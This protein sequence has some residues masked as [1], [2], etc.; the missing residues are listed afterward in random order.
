M[1]GD[2]NVSWKNLAKGQGTETC[3]YDIAAEWR[4][5]GMSHCQCPKLLGGDWT[6]WAFK[7]SLAVYSLVNESGMYNLCAIPGRIPT[8]FL[9]TL[10]SSTMC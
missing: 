8:L 3:H 6:P 5:I 1:A 4:Q 10:P 2:G 9:L 7:N